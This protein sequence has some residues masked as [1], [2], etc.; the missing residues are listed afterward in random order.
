VSLSTVGKAYTFKSSANDAIVIGD[1]DDE[2]FHP[3]FTLN[4]WNG[5]CWIKVDFDDSQTPENQKTCSS[6]A[7]KVEWSSPL[8]DFRYYPL[9]PMK[10]HEDGG[11]EFEI[12]LNAKPQQNTLR[13]TIQME[14]LRFYKQRPLTQEF[15]L[16]D[17]VEL[18]ETYVRLKDGAECWRPENV[19][20]SYAVYHDGKRG[21]QYKAGKAFHVYRPKLTGADGEIAWATLDVDEVAGVLTVML[22]Q[23]FIDS[24]KYPVVVDPTFGYTSVGAS[25]WSFG[26]SEAMW[27]CRFTMP[28]A[29]EITS[30][31]AYVRA[32][33]VG[34]EGS[35]AAL[36]ESSGGS[37]ASRL[38]LSSN[39]IQLSG[40]TESWQEYNV[41][42]SGL[43]ADYFLTFAAEFGGRIR[44]DSGGD[45]GQLA[46]KVISD[47]SDPP[48]PFGSHSTQ[49][50]IMSIYATYT[51]GA[52]LQSVE[53]SLSLGDAVLRNKT[54]TLYDALDLEDVLYGDKVLLLGDAASLSDLV[55]V[56]IVGALKQVTDSVDIIDVAAVLKTVKATDTV[57]LVDA[58]LTPARVLKALDAAGLADNSVVNKVLLITETASLAEVVQVDAGGAKKTK[59]FLIL[60][61]LAVQLTGD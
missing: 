24:A 46:Y 16:V 48:D 53:D 18:S 20:G 35:K 28:E 30:V 42:Y 54:L 55:T 58:A 39:D 9:S 11:L 22:P 15:A 14:G 6:A 34:P 25:S 41:S 50:R 8:F 60:G 52:T 19:V 32:Y 49:D 26:G 13:F 21:N 23:E 12:I 44:Y 61:D 51:A 1:P 45:S 3:K 37:P 47:Y 29:G 31:T 2:E 17:C 43:N 56:I 33:N 5:E 27:G 40:G 4:R 7:N 36:Y 38:A 10:Q 57:T 59:L